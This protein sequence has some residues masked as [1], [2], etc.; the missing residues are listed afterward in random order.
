MLL[1]LCLPVLL[2][3]PIICNG[4]KGTFLLSEMKVICSCSSCA[5]LPL[6]RRTFTPTQYEQHSGAGSAKKWKASLRIEPGAV[7]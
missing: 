5:V 3:I 1:S 2:Q 4:I 6:D 7:R